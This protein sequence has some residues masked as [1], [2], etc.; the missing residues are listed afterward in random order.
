VLQG[1]VLVALLAMALDQGFELLTRAAGR[2][3]QG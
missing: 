3:R 1:A 2:W